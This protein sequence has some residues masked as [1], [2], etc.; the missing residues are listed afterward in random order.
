MPSSPD[1]L[2][3]L[4]GPLEVKFK[5]GTFATWSDCFVRLEG[6]W[7]CVYKRE[8]DT[9]RQ[10]AIEIGPGVNV[11]DITNPEA[12]AKFPRRFDVS[13][14]G[15]LL[16]KTELC[17][18]T[19]SRKDR[20]LWVLAIA[21]NLR[22][23]CS[24]RGQDPHYGVRDLAP[25]A[26]KL[27]HGVKLH[28]IRIRSDL[29]VR[30]ATGDAIV[31]FLVDNGVVQDNV[32]AAGLCR[33]LLAMN[34]L[35]HVMWTRDFVE[36]PEPYVIVP[37]EDNVGTQVDSTGDDYQ[38]AHFLKYMD[39]RKFWKYIASADNVDASSV[40]ASSVST[41][42]F[43][44]GFSNSTF[45]DQSASSSDSSKISNASP[46]DDTESTRY[47]TVSSHNSAT[48][49][50]SDVTEK[51]A[52]KCAI[53]TKSF[54]PLRRRHHC[55]QCRAVVCS[56]C[57]VVRRPTRAGGET[58]TIVTP[59]PAPFRSCITCKLSSNTNFEGE[60]EDVLESIQPPQTVG[61]EDDLELYKSIL[62]DMDD[63]VHHRTTDL[64]VGQPTTEEFCH[65]CQNE[66][67]APLS[68]LSLMPYPVDLTGKKT[69]Y[70]S[71]T[72]MHNEAERLESVNSLLLT[73]A[74]TSSVTRVLRQF[75]NMAAIATQCPIA[76]I[77]L[78]DSENY[79]M[80]A[81]YGINL[82]PAV[83]RQQSF[84]AHTCRSGSALVCSDLTRDVRFVENPWRKEQLKNAA[85]YAGI[86]LIL[87]NGHAVGALEVFGLN[88]RYECAEVLGQ[89]QAVV[90][91]LLNL[92]EDVMSAAA[93]AQLEEQQELA[94]QAQ[95]EAAAQAAAEKQVQED[96]AKEL[97][98]N[99]EK[100]P[101]AMEAQLLQLLSQTT[102][103][104]EQL[105]AQQGQ[106]VSAISSHSKQIDNLAKQLERIE[107]TLA[108]KLDS[109]S[110]AE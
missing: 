73:M 36:S 22:C 71:A 56:N 32:T 38:I 104:Q 53:C 17:L 66:T 61:S 107:A 62:D 59:V 63:S 3:A 98:T 95:A 77:G 91:G 42:S 83:P 54:N 57:S 30:C 11:T 15:G 52:K 23:L 76:I 16:P 29:T 6:R 85:F 2:Q 97:K 10:G 28:P 5:G 51:K 74:A 1:S 48:L 88:P 100:P 25:V 44:R 27:R 7:L 67:C 47:S 103:T 109:S 60:A 90:R 34:L 106:M 78:L 65:L 4:S 80:G 64:A 14:S 50:P 105:R 12:S 99:A 8:R 45:L 110:P 82:G 58:E 46:M 89:L 9:L 39:S 31:A 93:Q 72:H 70:V 24:P 75:S 20:D 94:A 68:E 79:V 49:P 18:R 37:L 35:H 108:A 40:V 26:S 84:A 96:A 87:S 55:R 33:Q 41:G 19:K 13:C 69:E 43:R 102:S 86:P 81:Q 101:N 21:N 92:F